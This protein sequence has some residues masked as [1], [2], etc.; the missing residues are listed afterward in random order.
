LWGGGEDHERTVIAGERAGGA[1]RVVDVRPGRRYG[2][3]SNP[4]SHDLGQT[5]RTGVV[6]CGPWVSQG[7]VAGRTCR[8]HI[9]EVA[10]AKHGKNARISEAD[11]YRHQTVA[12]AGEHRR[13]HEP[14]IGERLA[15]SNRASQ[16]S[17][18]WAV[19]APEH[20]IRYG[21]HRQLDGSDIARSER[22][23][24]RKVMRRGEHPDGSRWVRSE[25]VE[26]RGDSAS[27][28]RR[29]H[30]RTMAQDRSP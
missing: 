20:P 27:C 2:D 5:G 6:G 12:E 24:G 16:D 22:S 17:P 11:R 4:R 19:A 3:H 15:A 30:E 18:D 14:A 25:H 26:R 29:G 21:G 13:A 8:E 10:R 28:Q 1:E 23:A 7:R 9:D